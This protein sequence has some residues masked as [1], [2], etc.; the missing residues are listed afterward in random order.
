[1]V[2]SCCFAV[3]GEHIWISVGKETTLVRVQLLVLQ[4]GVPKMLPRMNIRLLTKTY[5]RVLKI[6][7]LSDAYQLFL[8]ASSPSF[9]FQARI[10]VL[11]KFFVFALLLACLKK[12]KDKLLVPSYS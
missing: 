5:R 3:D 4:A 10:F 1:V 2:R 7:A 11:G 9:F 8:K 12:K 6:A